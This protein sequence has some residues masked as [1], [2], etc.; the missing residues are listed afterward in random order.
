MASF[1]QRVRGKSQGKK[2]QG[3][4]SGFNTEDAIALQRYRAEQGLKGGSEE[5]ID[6]DEVKTKATIKEGF[7]Q[8]Q[9][10]DG[11]WK[12]VR[13]FLHSSVLCVMLVAADKS[14]MGRLAAPPK[15]EIERTVT[16]Y[17]SS[18]EPLGLT[19]KGG[20]EHG[21]P[22]FVAAITEGSPLDKAGNSYVGDE[23]VSVEGIA[24]KDFTHSD[25]VSAIRAVM[26][27]PR[28][29]LRLR[30]SQASKYQLVGDYLQ[31]TEEGQAHL[32]SRR[33]LKW[34]ELVSIPVGL[35]SISRFH[36]RTDELR[37]QQAFAVH[38][39]FDTTKKVVLRA[40]Y[41][42]V[43]ITQDWINAIRTA[44]D[45]YPPTLLHKPNPPLDFS[46]KVVF[47]GRVHERSVKGTWK[48]FFM[49]VTD[50]DVGFCSSPPSLPEHL[51]Y[52]V[53]AYPLLATRFISGKRALEEGDPPHD[54]RENE[55][56]CFTLKLPDGVFHYF[57]AGSPECRDRLERV[58]QE[59][60][61]QAVEI[62]TSITY[63][64]FFQGE[65]VALT[66]NWQSGLWL[67]HDTV[68]DKSLIWHHPFS[69]L[70]NT[71]DLPNK[72]LE[73]EFEGLDTFRIQVERPSM[74]VFVIMAFVSCRA[75]KQQT[76][77][78]ASLL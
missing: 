10:I 19:I 3:V 53:A 30:F 62:M 44:R 51:E 28:V 36:E 15:T 16:V 21:V 59:R 24:L 58:F 45:N 18:G 1:I 50:H 72:T 5:L 9:D 73:F 23:I 57:S 35:C 75:R 64:C 12:D 71:R 27:R 17:K 63:S 2:G 13:V 41:G 4:V 61:D 47:C 33:H 22:I 32:R 25:A 48:D 38:S 20:K 11:S 37:E 49:V 29:R 66:I 31:T 42:D 55:E 60:T 56:G 78:K 69:R 68:G 76:L 6:W 77:Y 26:S 65:G 70:K 7:M 8:V 74:I 54:Q 40:E 52:P 46:G 34:K 14:A 39:A 43:Q 67:N